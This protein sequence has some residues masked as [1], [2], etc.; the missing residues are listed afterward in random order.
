MT[1]GPW[2]FPSG[3]NPNPQL[4]RN[5]FGK[6]NFIARFIVDP[7]DAP[8]SV[9]MELGQPHFGNIVMGMLL[10]DPLDIAQNI[11][12]PKTLGGCRGKR[13]G[14]RR[15]GRRRGIPS[16]DDMVAD[17]VREFGGSRQR[18][19][20]GTKA[21]F[22]AAGSLIQRAAW[23]WYVALLTVDQVYQWLSA[24][25]STQ[26]CQASQFG[27]ARFQGG[28]Y[29]FTGVPNRVIAPQLGTLTTKG[30]GFGN[31]SSVGNLD[32]RMAVSASGTIENRDNPITMVTVELTTGSG[33]NLEV[34]DSESFMLGPRASEGYN[35]SGSTENP[36]SA[37]VRVTSTAT[38]VIYRNSLFQGVGIGGLNVR[39]Y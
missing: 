2:E 11:H 39:G 18:P 6:L 8:F 22:I 9:Y 33:L 10:P 5:F 21:A 35:L 28:N 19:I 12:Q 15:P 17:R 25:Q 1:T 34:L 37:S 27:K 13:R 23:Q 32:H 29:A 14:G 26:F 4:D 20:S 31:I 16:L 24:V 3:Y 38:R 36:T 7:C 30:P